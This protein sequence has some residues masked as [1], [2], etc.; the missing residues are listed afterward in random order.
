[1][2]TSANTFTDISA[3]GINRTFL[4]YDQPVSIRPIDNDFSQGRVVRKTV[5]GS[6]K[7]VG[8]IFYDISSV[9][10][11]GDDA[12]AKLNFTWPASGVTGDFGFAVTGHNNAALSVERVRYNASNYVGRLLV[13][14]VASGTEFNFTENST[15]RDIETG[16]SVFDKPTSFIT[17]VGLYN[18]GG[19]LLA[20]GKL[21]QPVKKDE[22]ITLAAQIDLDF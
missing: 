16:E 19:D 18:D 9:V 10:L 13:D 6:I 5:E 11:D 22:N 20:V 2:A 17:T 4:Y 14:A 21:A 15:G 12:N 8:M 7:R 3:S 1:M